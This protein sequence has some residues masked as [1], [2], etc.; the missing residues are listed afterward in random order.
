M[1]VFKLFNTYPGGYIIDKKCEKRLQ[2][3]PAMNADVIIIDEISMVNKELFTFVMR[4][5]EWIKAKKSGRM[6]QVITVGDFF[7]LPPVRMDR[8][9]KNYA[10]DSPLWD[11]YMKMCVELETPH[12]QQDMEFCKRLL[13]IRRGVNRTYNVA[14]LKQHAHYLEE[15]EDAV[16]LVPRRNTAEEINTRFI[17]ALPGEEK[18]YCA[19]YKYARCEKWFTGYLKLCLKVGARVMAI[20]TVGG[21]RFTN[22]SFGTVV[23]LSDDS[24]D[25][26]FDNS[27]C[28][29]IVQVKNCCFTDD[30]GIREECVIQIPLIP[31]Y[32]LTIHRAQ[33]CTLKCANIDLSCFESGQFYVALSRVKSIENIF[34]IRDFNEKHIRADA[35]IADFY[36]RSLFAA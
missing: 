28:E 16:Y 33:G 20:A 15:N 4:A 6:I 24:V 31:A 30:N 7:Q 10:F 18:V 8:N 12:R 9:A 13:E 11:Q 26:L 21:G 32:A 2:K 25:V 35:R 34:I 17:A 22:G 19:K 36:R 5:V 14:W 23:S 1:T 29:D 27:H 3:S